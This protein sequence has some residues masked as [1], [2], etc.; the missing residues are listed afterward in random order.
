MFCEL[1]STACHAPTF[2][3]ISDLFYRAWRIYRAGKQRLLFSSLAVL[4]KLPHT[5]LGSASPLT[6]IN[7]MTGQNVL[8]FVFYYVL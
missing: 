3:Q 4:D 6:V 1:T 2:E 5:A 8:V 7:I